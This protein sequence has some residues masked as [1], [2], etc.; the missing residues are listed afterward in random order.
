MADIFD[1]V[2]QYPTTQFIGG[3]QTQEVVA[4]GIVTKPS[5][6]YVEF[7]VPQKGY[8]ANVV[9][10]AALGQATIFET[11]ASLPAVAGVQWAQT[12]NA[13]GYLVEVVI[14]T[15][16]STSGN[17]SAQLTVPV[18]QLGPQLHK[19]Q[20]LALRKQLDDAENL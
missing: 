13:A 1:V 16:A 15:V 18:V 20:I 9:D 19:A 2:A 4:V 7:L 8:S 3:T 14:I 12:Q 10:A 5:G 6:I 17:S 11:V